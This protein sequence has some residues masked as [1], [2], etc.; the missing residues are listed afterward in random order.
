M[1]YYYAPTITADGESRSIDSPEEPLPL[2][3]LP[4]PH[5]DSVKAKSVTPK[6]N[7]RIRVVT[8]LL[9]DG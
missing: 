6:L 8:G 1:E 7:S 4:P 5:Q 9:C 3:E 2:P